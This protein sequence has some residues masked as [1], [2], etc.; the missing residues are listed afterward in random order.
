M[1]RYLRR[2]SWLRACA[3]AASSPAYGFC[4]VLRPRVQEKVK[5]DEKLDMYS[6]VHLATRI[7]LRREGLETQTIETAVRRLAG[8]FPTDEYENQHIWRAYLPHALRILQRAG[9]GD[10]EERYELY[11]WVG[12][13]LQGEGRIKEA[14]RCFEECW[15]WRSGQFAEEHPSRLASQHE[16]AVA[17]RSDGQI[18]KAVA[19]LEQHELAR[20]YRSDGQVKKAVALLEQVV[21]V[22]ERTLAEEHP[23]RLASQHNLA[24][25]YQAD[26]RMPQAAELLKQVVAVES[27]TLEEDHPDRLVSLSAL[28][29][30]LEVL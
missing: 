17:Y 11:F 25:A 21:A 8:S 15:R 13:C 4:S 1:L 27:K 18:K 6:L 7:W 3:I 12:R 24:I 26:G 20:A 29:N 30:V 19:L 16:L 10:I 23:S 28:E 5:R 2:G 14:M 22:Q 9:A